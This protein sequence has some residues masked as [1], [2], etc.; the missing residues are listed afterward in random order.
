IVSALFDI[1]VGQAWKL[2]RVAQL[3]EEVES[4]GM[5]LEVIESVP[6]HEDIKLGR[7]SRDRLIDDYCESIRNI[8][9][10]GVRVLCYNFMP[11][12]DWMRTE[13]ARPLIDGS[14]AL[15]FE[16]DAISRIDLSRGGADLPGWATAYSARD[17]GVLLGAY[18]RVD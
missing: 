11:V 15:A 9:R 4:H 10:A 5:S 14:T 13:L 1:P 2:D 16:D 6:I 17:L 12:F 18:R 3:R 8:G 7:P